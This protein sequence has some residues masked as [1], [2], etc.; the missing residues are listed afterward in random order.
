VPTGDSRTSQA[1]RR[2]R[3]IALLKQVTL[4]C[5]V[6]VGYTGTTLREVSRRAGLS[7]GAIT[8]HFP[9]RRDLICAALEEAG[10]STLEAL[11]AEI[12]QVP[13]DPESRSA[14][15]V[16]LLHNLCYSGPL[17]VAWLRLWV[18]GAGDAELADVIGPI[19][20]RLAADIRN[21]I[22]AALPEAAAGEAETTAAMLQ[23]AVLGYGLRYVGPPNEENLADLL[24]PRYRSRLAESL[25][26]EMRAL[27]QADHS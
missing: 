11:R 24:W 16:D 14:A 8:H 27:E 10:G 13:S 22:A 5:L 21:A 19:S 23:I 20:Q 6:D 15:V 1:E 2:A 17:F 9:Q 18:A 7:Q 4:D 3:T 26:S 12:S 25:A